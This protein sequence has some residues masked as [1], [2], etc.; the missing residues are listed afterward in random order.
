MIKFNTKF[1]FIVCLGDECPPDIPQSSSS[2]SFKSLNIFVHYPKKCR[3]I[4]PKL[5][6]IQRLKSA[7][8]THMEILEIFVCVKGINVDI[9]QTFLKHLQSVF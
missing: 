9:F 6:Y 8:R 4:R 5:I 7:E 1:D 2:Y 3:E